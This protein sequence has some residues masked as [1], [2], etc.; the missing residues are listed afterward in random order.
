MY[1]Y[2]FG[3]MC[4]IHLN[5]VLYVFVFLGDRCGVLQEGDR[6]LTV[7]GTVLQGKT[8]DSATRIL[9]ESGIRVCLLVEFDV[10]G[11]SNTA[12]VLR[13]SDSRL[14]FRGL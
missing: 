5:Q 10:A 6:I 12:V 11:Q 4:S 14:Q 3:N 7:N 1:P 13:D 2:I 9:N 8:L